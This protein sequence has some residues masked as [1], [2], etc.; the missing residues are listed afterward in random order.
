MKNITNRDIEQYIGAV[1]SFSKRMYY[2]NNVIDTDDLIQAGFIGLL[3]GIRSFKRGKGTK[4][5]TYV[6]WCIRRA[7]M[8]EANKFY[9]PFKIP[10]AKKLL[11]NK[12]IKLVAKNATK[13]Q[14]VKQLELSNN[15]YE[16]FTNLLGKDITIEIPLTLVDSVK[17]SDHLEDIL[18][19][20]L[21]NIDKQILG[22]R[23]NN[24]TYANI[25]LITK[26]EESEVKSRYLKVL[27]RIKESMADG[28]RV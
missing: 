17:Y 13:A 25:A 21:S 12:F 4:K 18:S 9:G 28:T 11:L 10:H 8:E 3:S 23:L 2:S 14:I 1:Y 5:S 20:N 24:Y 6:I 16:L 22:F 15:D 27:E 26:L 19:I 7:I